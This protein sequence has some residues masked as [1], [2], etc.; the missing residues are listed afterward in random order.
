M[1]MSTFEK[2]YLEFIR[3]EKTWTRPQIFNIQLFDFA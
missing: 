3:K 2:D 1:T